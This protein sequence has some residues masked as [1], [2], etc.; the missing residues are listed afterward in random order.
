MKQLHFAFAFLL[1][2]TACNNDGSKDSNKTY[3]SSKNLAANDAGGKKP[4]SIDEVLSAYLQLKNALVNDNGKDAA[5][6]SE[7]FSDALQKIDE[8]SLTEEQKKEYDDEKEDLKEHADHIA[9]NANKISHQRDHFEWLSNGLYELVKV[10]KT[11]QTLYK[12]HCPMFNDGKGAIW[13]SEIK[14]IKN[15]YYGKKMITCGSVKEEIR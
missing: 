6:A 14:E 3:D 12:D 7:Q 15:P 2:V 11:N 1:L 5:A 4:V 9:D 10:F 8:A 13:L